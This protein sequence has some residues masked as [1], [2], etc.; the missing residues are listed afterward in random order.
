MA[1]TRDDVAA[2][3]T[4]PSQRSAVGGSALPNTIDLPVSVFP[5]RRGCAFLGTRS[6][7][8]RTT[9]YPAS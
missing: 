9:S 4:P 8:V 5:L 3:V 7:A 2:A 6:D 1:A